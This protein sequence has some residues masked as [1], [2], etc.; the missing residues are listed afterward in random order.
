MA[1]MMEELLEESNLVIEGLRSGGYAV[2]NE[3]E[4][5]TRDE[6]ISRRALREGLR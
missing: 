2:G 3:Y 1:R 5:F 4:V 6:L